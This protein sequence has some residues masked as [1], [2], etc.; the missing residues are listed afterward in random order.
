MKL[1]EAVNRVI[2][3]G[4]KIYDYYDAEL[5]KWHPNYPLVNLDDKEPPP[6][7]EE[8][9]LGDFLASLPEDMVYQLMLVMNVGSTLAETDTLADYYEE[10]KGEFKDTE[11]AV[12]FLMKKLA[13]LAFDLSEGLEELRKHKIN[14]DKL[15]LK[16]PSVRKR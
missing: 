4:S 7:P 3:L 12:S 2:D 15:P 13:S 5:P 16:K 11:D 10:M 8:K 1:S 6:P 9:E 14:V